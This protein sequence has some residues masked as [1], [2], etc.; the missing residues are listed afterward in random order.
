M[1]PDYHI[2]RLDGTGLHE[3][4]SDTSEID[5]SRDHFLTAKAWV[6]AVL[7]QKVDVSSDTKIFRF[8]LNHKD[9]KVGLP[10]GQHLMMRLRDPV[11]RESII[12]AYTPISPATDRGTLDVL[13]KIYRDTPEQKGGQMTQAL[14]AIPIGHF[15]DFKGPVGKF[16][17]LGGGLCSISGSTR[18]I[19]RFNMICGGS[20]ITPIFQVLR[21][22]SNDVEDETQCV[23]LDGNRMEEDIL[24]RTEIDKLAAS[25][26]EKCRIV[27]TLS[28]PSSSWTG[29]VGRMDKAFIAAEIGLPGPGAEELVLLCGPP[30]MERS[31]QEILHSIGWSDKDIVTF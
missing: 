5:P 8:K 17:Y 28:R 27:H 16:E 12:R 31:V 11:T 9:Q 21:A 20:G 14:D 2:G 10:V 26:Q 23:L 25:S 15:V 24:C 7:D 4:S 6:K 1:M 19:R 30:S 3:L 29:S 22:V 18:K 13:V